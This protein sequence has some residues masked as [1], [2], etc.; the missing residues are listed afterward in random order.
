MGLFASKRKPAPEESSPVATLPPKLEDVAFPA[1]IGG[2]GNCDVPVSGDFA[3]E[4]AERELLADIDERVA[5]KAYEL[6]HLATTQMRLLDLTANPEADISKLEKMLAPDPALTALLLKTA[7]SVMYAG[8]RTV[9]TVRGAILRVGVRGVRSALLSHSLKSVIFKDKTLVPIAEEVWRQSFSV[10]GNARANAVPLSFDP[11][12]AFVLGLLHDLGKVPLLGLLRDLA[13]PGFD[14]RRPFVGHV[15]ARHHETVGRQLAIS[16]NLPEEVIDVAGCHHE[17]LSCARYVKNAALVSLA[18]RQDMRL[19]T[20]DAEGY[21][22][23]ADGPEMD[24]LELPPTMRRPLLEA[25][26]MSY[27]RNAGIAIP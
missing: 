17:F 5:A 19:S 20:G 3:L 6:P 7:N 13:K 27:L 1:P 11:E 10:A 21:F 9:D 24:A 16:W 23:L 14:F 18:H 15:F 2:F 26:R 22:A 8:T 12:R 4:F 25:V